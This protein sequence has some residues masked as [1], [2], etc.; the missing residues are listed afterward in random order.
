[1][2]TYCFPSNVMQDCTSKDPQS[3]GFALSQYQIEVPNICCV[4]TRL[5]PYTRAEITI[6]RK[7]LV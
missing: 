5:A 3:T 6:N 4:N 2:Q 7:P 1:M